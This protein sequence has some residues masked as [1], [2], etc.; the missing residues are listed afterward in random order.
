MDNIPDSDSEQSDDQLS[1]KSYFYAWNLTK[2]SKC[3]LFSDCKISSPVFKFNNSYW[4]LHMHVVSRKDQ[5]S[6][7]RLRLNRVTKDENNYYLKYK[8]SLCDDNG[9]LAAREAE[10]KF[11]GTCPWGHRVIFKHRGDE[12]AALDH[13]LKKDKLYIH[14]DFL[15]LSST[16]SRKSDLD[17]NNAF[18]E[19]MEKPKT[20]S[21]L[22]KKYKSTRMMQRMYNLRSVNDALIIALLFAV[23]F[24]IVSLSS[25]NV[26]QRK[27]DVG[28]VN[29][30]II[31]T[32]LKII[33]IA[34]ALNLTEVK[35]K[36]FELLSMLS[37]SY[38]ISD[39]KF[40]NVSLLMKNTN[41]AN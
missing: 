26:I 41:M 35:I 16:S 9:P 15:V 1:L 37:N 34:D 18:E 3:L 31:D 21:S 11:D 14:C 7:L 36:S 20:R 23:F 12:K 2:F 28:K 8:F 13:M 32:A 10:S 22:G 40:H 24:M 27:E 25:H 6:E 33:N 38:N 39:A 5:L 19:S 4:R 17:N 30:L 29:E